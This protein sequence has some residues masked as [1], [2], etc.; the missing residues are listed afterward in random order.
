M[1]QRRSAHRR[2]HFHYSTEEELARSIVTEQYAVRAE[3][4]GAIEQILMH[5]HGYPADRG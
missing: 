1:V 3:P 5:C 4:V 2:M